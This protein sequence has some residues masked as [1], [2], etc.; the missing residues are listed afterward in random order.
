MKSY[1]TAETKRGN[2][3]CHVMLLQKIYGSASLKELEK[4]LARFFKGLRLELA[5]VE[6]G[7]NNWVRIE[8]KGEDAKVAVRLLERIGKLAPIR[9][10]KIER[11]S[12]LN[13]SVVSSGE[14]KGLSVDVGLVYPRIVYGMVHLQHLRGQLVDGAKL[15]IEQLVEL[16][17]LADHFPIGIRV[18][19][20]GAHRLE[21]ELTERQLALYNH[22]INGMVDRLI[23][24]GSSEKEVKEAVEKTRLTRDIVGIESLGLFE[25]VV[26]CKLGTDARGLIARIGKR[27]YRA[28][29]VAFSPREILEAAADQWSTEVSWFEHSKYKQQYNIQAQ[30]WKGK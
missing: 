13:G 9:M 19:G 24:L 7:E 12:V 17:G 28:R 4:T 8:V 26:V 10:E 27:L 15:T 2:F 30:V 5:G 23:I 29:L 20:I 22:W 3:M 16:F 21:A 25:Q 14:R 1:P 6:T 11:Y 18:T